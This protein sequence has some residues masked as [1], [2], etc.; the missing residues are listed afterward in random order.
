[1]QL[2]GAGKSGFGQTRVFSAPGSASPVLTETR[3]RGGWAML[4]PM[5]AAGLQERHAYPYGINVAR[6]GLSSLWVGLRPMPNEMGR[7]TLVTGRGSMVTTL[8]LR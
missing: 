7:K 4:S 3:M 8:P 5:F 6:K 2:S 1:M